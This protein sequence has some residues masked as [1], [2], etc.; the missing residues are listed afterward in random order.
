MHLYMDNAGVG[1]AF[2]MDYAGRDRSTLGGLLN[3]HSGEM[4]KL[5]ENFAVIIQCG[6]HVI[7]TN[8]TVFCIW[9]F[10]LL[11]VVQGPGVWIKI[12]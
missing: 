11:L 12:I 3:P 4:Y 6:Q 8:E 1:F 2:S 9:S 7:L 10:H 5:F